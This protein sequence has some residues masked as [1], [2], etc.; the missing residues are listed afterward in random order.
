MVIPW[1]YLCCFYGA[2]MVNSMVILYIYISIQTL[3]S[4]PNDSPHQKIHCNPKDSTIDLVRL[5][6]E[7]KP[8]RRVRRKRPRFCW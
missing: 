2:S 5:D 8:G 7:L 6:Q 3:D 4:D 1:L